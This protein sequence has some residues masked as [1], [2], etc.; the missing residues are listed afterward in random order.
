[1]KTRINI[2]IAA[3]LLAC[4]GIPAVMAAPS[5]PAK[6]E[7]VPF[8]SMT[9][10]RMPYI[11]LVD[12]AEN[13]RLGLT[14]DPVTLTMTVSRGAQRISV[15]NLS[16][17]A[18]FNKEPVKL[19][20]P[21]RLIRGAMYVPATTFLPALSRMMHT[22]LLWDSRRNGVITPG[23]T[24]TVTGVS[25]EERSQGTLIRISLGAD[26]KYRYETGRYNWI[27]ITFEDGILSRSLGISVPPEG[28]V[29]D[30]RFSQRENEAQLAFRITEDMESY[31]VSRAGDSGDILIA[32]RKRR[33]AAAA[34]RKAP[35]GGTVDDVIESVVPKPVE[36]TFDES[37]WRIDTVIID[38]GHGGRDSGAVGFKGT[39]EKD[40]VLATAKELKKLFDER[41]EVN[42]V[43]TRSSD[44]FV[45]LYQRAAVAKRTN[46]KLFVS[47][48]ANAS[49]NRDAHGMEVFFLSAAKTD[50]ARMVADRENAS[51]TYE[52]NPAASRKMLNGSNLLSDIERDMASN[53]F[54]KE[55]QDL[56]TVL[57][58]SAIPATRQEN[59]GV[60]QAGFYVLA[61]TLSTMPSILFEVGF[62]SNPEEE[63]MLNRISYQKRIAQAIYDAVIKFKSRHERGLFSRSR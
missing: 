10:D 53:V 6:E 49:K 13:Y 41:G 22:S 40:V 31:D 17:T 26:L 59:R 25:F 12:I 61:G 8:N 57:L 48:H 5:A 27:T 23:F 47:I 50:D 24:S 58:D 43:M 28:M 11:S 15:A 18:R 39:K 52:D 2:V 35:T 56:C 62:I 60:K 37:E 55:S 14:Y 38:P 45:G 30:S 33:P 51:V 3:F 42:A 9:L 46:G 19:G 4:S 21:A 44:V 63:R 34:G 54:L 32:L 29:L 7:L 36:P 16:T 1:M 20:R